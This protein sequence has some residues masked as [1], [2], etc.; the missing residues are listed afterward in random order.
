MRAAF[1]VLTAKLRHGAA[2]ATSWAAFAEQA[3]K[4]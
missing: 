3:A 1:A 2:F 4:L